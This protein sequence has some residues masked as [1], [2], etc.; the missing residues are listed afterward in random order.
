MPVIQKNTAQNKSVQCESD[1]FCNR[2]GKVFLFNCAVGI[3]DLDAD[4]ISSGCGR[5]YFNC[6][7]GIVALGCR[8]FCTGS[9]LVIYK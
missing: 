2:E 9:F 7:V 1:L 3:L 5:F 4:I 8:P 6:R